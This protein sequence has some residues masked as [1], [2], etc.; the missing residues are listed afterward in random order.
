MTTDSFIGDVA[1]NWNL[2]P[3]TITQARLSKMAKKKFA[4]IV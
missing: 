2:A 1:R 3:A 4:L